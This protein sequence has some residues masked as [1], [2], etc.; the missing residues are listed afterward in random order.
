MRRVRT[1]VTTALTALDQAVEHWIGYALPPPARA[2]ADAAFVA[3]SPDAACPRCGGSVGEGEVTDGRCGACRNRRGG[4][5]ATV[6]LGRFEDPLR[7]W[8]HL[9][10]YSAWAEMGTELGRLLG[11][12][13]RG[14]GRVDLGR[15]G[16]Q[17]RGRSS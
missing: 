3:E 6:R 4:L 17:P 2:I 9:V 12:R 11:A 10:K 8:V 13:V 15:F 16:W 14:S 1:H 5:D 7:E